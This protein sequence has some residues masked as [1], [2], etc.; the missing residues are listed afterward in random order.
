MAMSDQR[1]AVIE[2]PGELYR[3]AFDG[4][5][6][7]QVLTAPDGHLLRVNRA[8]CEML[9]YSDRELLKMNWRDVTHPEDVESTRRQLERAAG[10]PDAR[11]RLS[12]RYVKKDGAVVWADVSTRAVLVGGVVKHFVTSMMDITEQKRAEEALR[13]SEARLR[14]VLDASNDGFWER[15]LVTGK[16]MHSARM[17]EMLGLPAVDTYPGHDDWLGRMHPDDREK[18]QPIYD[19]VLS[20]KEER[21][22]LVFRTR[23]ADGSWMWIRARAK[24][25]A[26]NEEGEPTG[27]SGTITDVHQGMVTQVALRESEARFRALTAFAPVGIFQTDA[28]GNNVFLNPAGVTM[29][30][31]TPEEARGAGWTA[32]IH[33]E[34]RER[35]FREWTDAAA[36]GRD[37][38]SEYRFLARDGKVTW[39]RCYGSGIRDPDRRSLGYV[40]VFVDLTA[41]RTMQE[42]LQVASRLAAMGTLVAGVAHEINNPLAGTMAGQGSAIEDLLELRE[43]ACR[44][45]AIDPDALVRELDEDLG[46][47]TDAQVGAQRI[48]SIVKDLVT[49]G[50]PDPRRTRV[51][52]V[53]VVEEGMRWLPGSNVASATI[54]VVN[55]QAPDVIASSGQL[56]QVIVNLLTNAARSIPQDR[57]GVVTIRIGPGSPGMARVEVTDDG[58]GIRPEVRARIFDPFFTT[59]EVGQGMG[60]GLPICHA[61]V[62]AHGGTITVESEL[63][64]GSTFR[65][66]LP[67]A[68][69]EA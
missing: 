64:K 30:G 63:G 7:G 34:D 24:V 65:V 13:V 40:G 60:L 5:P 33:P 28:S 10:S 41:Q 44:R 16:V 54:R 2:A 43:R 25:S 56:G 23:H 27:F 36:A 52:L 12:K 48:A 20:G 15:D 55:D 57:R 21:I 53:D 51:R 17:N 19:R 22:D 8:L 46:S 31:L 68:P 69:A 9:G 42:Q 62:T 4:A 29:M 50:R 49:F 1:D 66:E 39:V 58:S 59:R 45:E 35:V 26:R 47:L 3:A 18:L 38:S 67:A 14:A 11:G 32:A 6:V 37:L 61:I